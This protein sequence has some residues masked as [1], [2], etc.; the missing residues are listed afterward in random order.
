MSSL[1]LLPSGSWYLRMDRKKPLS[2]TINLLTAK[3]KSRASHGKTATKGCWCAILKCAISQRNSSESFLVAMGIFQD[4]AFPRF[5]NSPKRYKL[6]TLAWSR[7]AVTI[8]VALMQGTVEHFFKDF[9][10]DQGRI[11]FFFFFFFSRGP[12]P[13]NPPP[14]KLFGE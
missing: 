6:G 11:F 5:F 10:A 2:L 7:D 12:P 14:K 9:F 3:A 4:S 13:K 8:P 1:L